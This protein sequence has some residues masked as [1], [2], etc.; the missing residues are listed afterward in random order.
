MKKCIK[1]NKVKQEEDFRFKDSST[2]L[3]AGS[4]KDCKKEYDKQWYK[5]SEKRRK[6]VKD[7]RTFIK[8][9]NRQFVASYLAEHPCVDCGFSDIRALDFDHLSDKMFNISHMNIK[10]FSLENIKAEISKCEVRC[11]NCHRIVTS[12]RRALVRF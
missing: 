5:S 10:G 8:L 7:K 12:E 4:C 1:C 2:G 11:A 3:R 6:Y 9:R